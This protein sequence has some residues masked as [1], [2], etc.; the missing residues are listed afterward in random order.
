[1]MK[2]LRY[3]TAGNPRKLLKPILWMVLANI[4]NLFPFVFMTV[5]VSKVYDY[6]E[7]PSST[8]DMNSLWMAWGGMVVFLVIVFVCER[9]SYRNTYRSAF[10]DSAEGRTQLAEHIRRLPLGFLTSKSSRNLGPAMMNDFTQIENAAIHLLPQLISGV[11]LPVIA[12]SGL[13]FVDWRMSVAMMTGFPISMLILWAVSR[14][15]RQLGQRHAEARIVQSSCLQEYLV[16]MKVIKANN[17]CGQN[18]TRLEQAFR[19]YMKESIKLEGVLGPFF[20]IAIAFFEVGLALIAMTGVYLILDGDI[21]LPVFA[22]FLLIGTRVFEPLSIA[23][24]RLPAFKYDAMAGERIARIW[25]QPMMTGEQEPRG[26][27]DIRFENV[28]FGYDKHIVL[29]QI[30]ATMKEGTLTAIVGPSGSGKSTM[31]RLIARFYDPQYGKVLL[32][33]TDEREMNPE[34][35]LKHISMVF[36]DVYLFSDTIRN[37]IRYGR[38]HASQADIELAAKEACCH[39]FIMKL[40]QGYDTWVGEGGSTLSGGEKQRIS[41]ARAILKNAPVIL[42]DEATSAL[43]PENEMDMQ[44]AIGRLIKGRTVIM[45]AHRLKTIINADNIIVLNKGRIVDQGRH[46]ELLRTG[47]HYARLWE[48]KSK[49]KGW[50]IST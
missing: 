15:E 9:K 19:R 48:I 38:E 34:K 12:L 3:I 43:D 32:G 11:M 47:G 7:N 1:M 44:K 18:F 40:P 14:L 17:L 45:I 26:N 31:L 35:L 23:I 29:E 21:S 46:E 36:Q 20:L 41:I 42:L 22:M 33:G 30:S 50:Q 5:L 39:D 49:A 25:A 16:G 6:F 2:R 8:L 4:A 10:T 37:N 28:T 27:H 24:M 13:L